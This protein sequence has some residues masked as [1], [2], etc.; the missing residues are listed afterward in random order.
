[1]K[2]I[3]YKP[4]KTKSMMIFFYSTISLPITEKLSI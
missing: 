4:K 2:K 3:N 1:M